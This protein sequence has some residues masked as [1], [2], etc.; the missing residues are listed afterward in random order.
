VFEKATDLR[1]SV[2]LDGHYTRIRVCAIAF[3][4]SPSVRRRVRDFLDLA[5]GGPRP[6]RRSIYNSAVSFLRQL[7]VASPRIA[8]TGAKVTF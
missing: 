1:K 8:P 5:F 7:D 6:A 4:A 3:H 2:K